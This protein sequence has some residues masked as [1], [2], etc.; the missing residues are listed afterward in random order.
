MRHAKND[1]VELSDTDLAG[2][3][4]P[5]PAGRTRLADGEARLVDAAH[6]DTGAQRE[7]RLQRRLVP[8]LELPSD[9]AEPRKERPRAADPA[10]Q[11]EA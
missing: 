5:A 6:H 8:L 7:H 3:V 1:R 2:E 11:L 4:R 9:A 10:E